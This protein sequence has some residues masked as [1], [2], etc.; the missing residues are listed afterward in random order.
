VRFVEKKLQVKPT[1]ISMTAR[2]A[3][4]GYQLV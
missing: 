1:P 2:V 3:G 4:E